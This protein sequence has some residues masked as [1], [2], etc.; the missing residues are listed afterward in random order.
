[1]GV[2]QQQRALFFRTHTLKGIRWYEGPNEWDI[3]LEKDE[4]RPLMVQRNARLGQF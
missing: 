1:M 4:S 3:L 2:D